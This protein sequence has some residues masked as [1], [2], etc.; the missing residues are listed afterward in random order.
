M[1]GDDRQGDLFAK[2]SRT[3]GPAYDPKIDHPRVKKQHEHIR[4]VMLT[5]W[6]LWRTLAEI[7]AE[8][9]YPQASISAQLRHLRKPRFGGYEV[10]KR[11][12]KVDG[13]TWEY[14]V[15]PHWLSGKVVQLR[16]RGGSA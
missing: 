10:Q 2:R 9:K 12:R 1:K 16:A 4:D 6:P 11:R 8:T 7:E 5:W 15:M 3:F 14:R 13:G